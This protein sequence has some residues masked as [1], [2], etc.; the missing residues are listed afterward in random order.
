MLIEIREM[1][2]VMWWMSTSKWKPGIEACLL[3]GKALLRS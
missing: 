3:E 1:Y 2:E